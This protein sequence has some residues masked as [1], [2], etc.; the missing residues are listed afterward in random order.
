MVPKLV[1]PLAMQRLGD[2]SPMSW[3]LEGFLDI[4]VRGGGVAEVLPECGQ[5]LVFAAVCLII[6]VWQF[7]RRMANVS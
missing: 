4:F 6:A 2:L 1:M 5:L 7:A 3:G